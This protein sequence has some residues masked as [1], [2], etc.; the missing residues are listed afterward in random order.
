MTNS[1]K[2]KELGDK[3]ARQYH[4]NNY[5]EFSSNSEFVFSNK[6]IEQACNE[7][8]NWKDQR[9]NLLLDAIDHAYLQLGGSY[10]DLAIE[11]V[12]KVEYLKSL[13]Q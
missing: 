2:A 6:E 13:R 1:E 3:F 11:V 4:H 8:A 5:P 10:G 7:M 12:D 9:I